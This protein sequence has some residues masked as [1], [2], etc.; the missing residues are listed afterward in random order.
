MSAFN[1]ANELAS[2]LLYGC[3]YIDNEPCEPCVKLE[4]V[5]LVRGNDRQIIYA[6]SDTSH[7]S[8]VKT[9][10]ILEALFHEGWDVQE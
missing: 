10:T 2:Q 3:H 6:P 5:V 7:M 9:A 4:Q 8:W 1:D